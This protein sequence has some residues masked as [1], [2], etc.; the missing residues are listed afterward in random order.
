MNTDQ[1]LQKILEGQRLAD[2][3]TELNEL[4]QHRDDVEALLR[5]AFGTTPTFRY[6]GSKAKGTLIREYYDLDLAFYCPHDN[7]CA[8]ETLKD[9]YGSVKKTLEKSYF[10]AP[11]R[12]ALRLKSKDPNEFGRDFHIDVVPGR[13]VDDSESDCFL[14]QENCD[15]ERLKTNLDVHIA[16]VRTSEVVPAICLLKLWKV[17]RGLRVK[18]FVFE[19]LIIKILKDKKKESLSSQLEAVWETLR[20]TADPISVEDPANPTGNDL[21]SRAAEMWAELSQ[22]ATTTL[23]IIKRSGWEAVFGAVQTDE[24]EGEEEKGHRSGPAI[25]I[26]GPPPGRP[27]RDRDDRPPQPDR[28]HG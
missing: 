11:K 27:R 4:R 7:A 3:S 16:H 1:Y 14:H 5:A 20:D 18:Q 21:T 6:G 22:A 19:L 13:F 8:G 9:I 23:E 24:E 25:I 15:K 2:D 10:V 28:R 17:R 12:T 26:P